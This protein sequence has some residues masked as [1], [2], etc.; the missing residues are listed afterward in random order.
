MRICTTGPWNE[1]HDQNVPC[2]ECAVTGSSHAVMIPGAD[3]CPTGYADVYTG[4][5]WGAH[6][7]GAVSS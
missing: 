7:G 3:A 4:T 2:V 6:N 5:V 1:A